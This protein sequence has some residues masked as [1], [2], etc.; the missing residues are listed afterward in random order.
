ME[1]WGI[2]VNGIDPE[3]EEYIVLGGWRWGFYG[4]FFL[5]MLG[6]WDAWMYGCMLCRLVFFG[7]NDGWDFGWMELCT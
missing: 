7:G 4:A 1:A 3:L 2:L 5:R 6:C